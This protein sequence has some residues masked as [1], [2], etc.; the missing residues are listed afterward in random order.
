MSRRPMLM[1][2]GETRA[3]VNVRSRTTRSIWADPVVP[4]GRS[5]GVDSESS[6]PQLSNGIP[7]VSGVGH[8]VRAL[9]PLPATGGR[10]MPGHGSGP[11]ARA[12][13]VDI[14]E[15][16][17]DV[18]TSAMLESTDLAASAREASRYLRVS[19]PVAVRSVQPKADLDL[20]VSARLHAPRGCPT[21]VAYAPSP[22]VEY[23]DVPSTTSAKVSITPGIGTVSG[24]LDRTT[25]H[26]ELV[27]NVV[28]VGTTLL[29]WTIPGRRGQAASSREFRFFVRQDEGRH[30]WLEMTVRASVARSFLRR[31]PSESAEQRV[32]SPLVAESSPQAATTLVL[33]EGHREERDGDAARFYLGRPLDLPLSMT[34]DGPTVRKPEGDGAVVGS[35]RWFDSVDGR[36]GFQWI[37]K[38]SD[39]VVLGEDQGPEIR[40]GET[41]FVPNGSVLRLPDGRSLCVVYD[42]ALTTGRPTLQD[43]LDVSV[44]VDGAVVDTY[45]TTSSYV[46]IGR[47]HKD[48]P[49]DRPDVSRMHGALELSDDGWSYTHLS[50]AG[51]AV[52]RREGQQDVDV[53]RHAA[54]PVQRRDTVVLNEHVSLSIG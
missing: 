13:A 34:A 11:R 27:S 19:I 50:G 18:A 41:V 12:L 9:K 6:L 22:S 17:C 16:D 1:T 29:E 52:L 48:I 47:S 54:V 31:M 24:G 40:P 39:R 42:A 4:P 21:P 7:H 26:Q 14:G 36:P 2:T 8:D 38:T 23:S 5:A 53:R 45:P 35:F 51:D 46:T 20:V 37:Q 25:S 32:W 33:F 15:I 10:S 30:G 43:A 28:G 44:V 3:L 49:I